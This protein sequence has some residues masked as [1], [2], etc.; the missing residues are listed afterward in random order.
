[1]RR[2]ALTLALAGAFGACGGSGPSETADSVQVSSDTTSAGTGSGPGG[3][4][5]S[6]SLL[7]GGVGSPSLLTGGVGS[8]SLATGVSGSTS[9]VSSSG[10]GQGSV[11]CEDALNASGNGMS[12]ACNSCLLG[13]CC[14]QILDCY[15][16]NGNSC[17][18]AV[19][20]EEGSCASECGGIPSGDDSGEDSSTCVGPGSSCVTTLDC[21]SGACTSGIC[22]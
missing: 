2:I 16:S 10:Q 18:G 6:P 15:N 11:T 21:C 1:M 17:D 7:T 12:D 14:S 20:C 22:E 13:S 8:P 19:Q 3:A 9:T 5:G 4:I